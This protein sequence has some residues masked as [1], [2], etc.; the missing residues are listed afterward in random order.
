MWTETT[1]TFCTVVAYSV[2]DISPVIFLEEIR[3]INRM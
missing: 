1:V 3:K 2:V